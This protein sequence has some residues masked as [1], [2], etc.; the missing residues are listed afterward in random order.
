[1]WVLWVLTLCWVLS[2]ANQNKL[3]IVKVKRKQLRETAR[4]IVN[5]FFEEVHPSESIN[6]RSLLFGVR[7]VSN[8]PD[9]LRKEELSN[10]KKIAAI[11]I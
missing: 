4:L 7:V 1:M 5:V 9:C 2:F 8:I 11:K 10:K 3:T 6:V